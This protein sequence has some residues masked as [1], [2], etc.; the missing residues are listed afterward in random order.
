MAMEHIVL[1]FLVNNQNVMPYNPFSFRKYGCHINIK[2]CASICFVKYIHKY[3]YKGHNCLTMQFD[4]EPNEVE[5]YF[6][7]RA[8]KS[9][10]KPKLGPGYSHNGIVKNLGHDPSSQH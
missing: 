10:V 5:Q 7:W 3:I 6:D 9:L 8:P 2:V 4:H 1:L